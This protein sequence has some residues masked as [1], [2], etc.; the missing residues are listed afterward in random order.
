M[1]LEVQGVSTGYGRLTVVHDASLTVAPG[2]VVAIVGPNGAGKSSLMK[3]IARSLPLSAGR[4]EFAGTDLST[5]PQNRI[6]GLGIGYVPQRGNVFPELSVEENLRVSCRAASARLAEAIAE[7]YAQFPRLQDRRQQVASTLS[8]G[9]RQMLAIACATMSKPSLLMLDEPTT[10]LAPIVVRER[11]EDI[12]RGCATAARRCCGSS[13]STRGSACPPWTGSTSC[14]TGRWR[15]PS[16][17]RTSSPRAR[18]RSC[19]S[20]WPAEPASAH[21]SCGR[22]GIEVGRGLVSSPYSSGRRQPRCPGMVR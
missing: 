2:E 20:G 16:G 18:S 8:G 1:S 9:E 21:C 7:V 22:R 3:A 13:R 12:A 17:P 11:I 19:S 15:R 14:P 4:I 5:V 6:A 10:G